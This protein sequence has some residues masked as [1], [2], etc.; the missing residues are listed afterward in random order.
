MSRSPRKTH[1]SPEPGAARASPRARGTDARLAEGRGALREALALARLATND[2]RA[3]PRKRAEALLE[4]ARLA[5]RVGQA[6][7][8]TATLRALRRVARGTGGA[9]LRLEAP[10]Q[11]P[12][13][14]LERGRHTRARVGRSAARLWATI[15]PKPAPRSAASSATTSSGACTASRA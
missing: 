10:L 3:T 5:W 6:R 15:V 2:A 14:A 7:E 11:R 1:G 13:I 12:P 8:A 4:R 9:P